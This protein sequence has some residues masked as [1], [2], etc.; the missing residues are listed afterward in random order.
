MKPH[1]KLGK[2]EFVWGAT[3]AT[4]ASPG[5]ALSAIAGMPRGWGT[6]GDAILASLTRYGKRDWGV[7]S[8]SPEQKSAGWAR[9]SHRKAANVIQSH[10]TA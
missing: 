4:L 9:F 8:A 5:R 2:F 7:G 6:L 3:G 1:L 10:S